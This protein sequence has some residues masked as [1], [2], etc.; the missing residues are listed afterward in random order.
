VE[1]IQSKSKDPF[2]LD[3]QDSDM[4][5]ESEGEKKSKAADKDSGLELNQSK[6]QEPSEL[7]SIK[8]D[9]SANASPLI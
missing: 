3:M 8:K 5:D 4:I 1:V 6:P 7:S 9:E 2:S